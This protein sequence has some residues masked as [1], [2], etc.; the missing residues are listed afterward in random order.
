MQEEIASMIKKGAIAELSKR[1][2]QGGFYSN[3]FLVPKK[4]GKMR[5]V[6]NLKHLNQFV[7]DGGYA[8]SK[9]PCPAERLDDQNRFKRRIL[10]N[11]YRRGTSKAPEIHDRGSFL[12]IH[13]SPLQVVQRSLGFHQDPKT[14]SD[15]SQ[16]TR[17]DISGRH[18]IDGKLLPEGERPHLSVNLSPTKS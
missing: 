4:D 14:S 17:G 10:Y 6:I 2:A 15:H 7:Q 1:E 16:R 3:M 8:H 5:P 9:R 13:L 18:I 12:P 11:P